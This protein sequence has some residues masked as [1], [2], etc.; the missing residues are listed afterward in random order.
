MDIAKQLRQRILSGHFEAGQRFYSI[1]GLIKE[2]QRSLPTV[3]SA[4]NVLIKEGLLEAR[5]GSGYYVTERVASAAGAKRGVTHFLAVIPSTSEPDEPWFM[6][7]LGLGMIHRART[8]I[9]PWCHFTNGGRRAIIPR[10]FASRIWSEFWRYSRM[11]SPG[12][13][14]RRRTR[15]C[16]RN[17]S[18]GGYLW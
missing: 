13:I 6:R 11:E 4:L 10:S 3:R 15:R 16:W 12:C 2:T 9:M 17:C 18:G 8:E 1:R 5:Q 14:A 7:R